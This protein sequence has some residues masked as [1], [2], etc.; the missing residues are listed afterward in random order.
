MRADESY[1]PVEGCTAE[2][3][4]ACV[5]ADDY[6]AC[7]AACNGEEEPGEEEGEIKTGILTVK[8]V[9]LENNDIPAV[10]NNVK[11]L[12][13]KV[14]PSEN[15]TL[16]GITVSKWTYTAST[17]LQS[18]YIR[19]DKGVVLTNSRSM[20]NDGDAY[21]TFKWGYELKADTTT[22]FNV[23][24]NVAAAPAEK[25]QVIL[26]S[27]DAIESSAEK[28]TWSFPINWPTLTTITYAVQT[29]SVQWLTAV[30]ATAYGTNTNVTIWEKAVEVAR[31][32]LESDSVN[33]RNVVLDTIRLKSNKTISEY[34]GNFSVKLWWETVNAKIT[35]D[36]KYMYIAFPEGY[37][38]EYGNSKVLYVYADVIWW[39]WTDFIQLWIDDDMDV[40]A[41]EK[42]TNAT[43]SLALTTPA[44]RA[45][46]LK[47]WDLLLTKNSE[48]TP[49]ASNISD[50]SSDNIMLVANL[51]TN[52]PI[53]V[54]WIEVPVV[55]KNSTPTNVDART[56]IKRMKLYKGSSLLGECEYKD[57]N[58]PANF[59]DD[60]YKCPVYGEFNGATNKLTI[61]VDTEKSTVWTPLNDYTINSIALAWASFVN[62]NYVNT[63]NGA[64]VIPWTATAP[65][66]TV[67]V[68]ALNDIA[69]ADSFAVWDTFVP[70]DETLLAKFKFSSN[71]VNDIVINS[72]DV[73]NSAG[74]ALTAADLNSLTIK[75]GDKEVTK[76][77]SSYPVTFNSLNMELKKG[78]TVTVELYWDIVRTFANNVE[79][80]INN[81]TA[82]A[83]TEKSVVAIAAPAAYTTT[84]LTA[85]SQAT[86]DVAKLSATTPVSNIIVRWSDATEIAKYDFKF[87][88]DDV[89]LNSLALE[90]TSDAY[91]LAGQF[92]LWL[93]S[94]NE[95]WTQ[96]WT[97]QTVLYDSAS[98]KYYVYFDN[99]NTKI[100]KW[101]TA[102]LIVK[103]KTDATIDSFAKTNKEV[104]VQPVDKIGTTTAKSVF[105]SLA[106]SV[107]LT[108][109]VFTTPFVV[110]NTMYVRNTN[111]NV[112]VVSADES[113]FKLKLTTE[114]WV[115]AAIATLPLAFSH[116]GMTNINF[117]KVTVA[118]VETAT[119]TAADTDIKAW[120]V[121]QFTNPVE[122]DGN[123][124]EVEIF[125]NLVI[126]ASKNTN[127]AKVRV[128][129]AGTA[130]FAAA[131]VA[132]TPA[133]GLEWFDGSET[134]PSKTVAKWFAWYKVT[135][136]PTAW[137]TIK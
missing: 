99:L 30:L 62:V 43:L 123:W 47:E 58:T 2:E 113:S 55:V 137:A 86:V 49:I 133:R 127:T 68:T 40:I 106:N 39:E 80:K 126:D 117:E 44:S 102:N 8:A 84:Q 132:G 92:E 60:Y 95:T 65:V 54:E 18:L 116:A 107:D 38:L 19:D 134:T 36:W 11:M 51:K 29:L 9:S 42:E 119:A 114:G 96:L 6:D 64:V 124:T 20:T 128:A 52:T 16:K 105:V 136:L 28:V 22:T 104:T 131:V 115:N 83:I 78:E 31:Y 73:A 3:L 13:I 50:N 94:W 81:V 37:E 79:F 111:L 122:I 7:I 4:L 46:D 1:T 88:K 101:A 25:L 87:S 129:D 70:S 45:Y 33:N 66:F 97:T 24:A 69:K 118:G 110:S 74:N 57:N 77:V 93:K 109:T 120:V 21:L 71:N 89:Q 56:L 5:T 130:S 103:F 23:Y 112:E 35:L 15:V 90:T 41:Y 27:V 53:Y 121:L 125:Y 100:T 34:Y 67:K 63:D 91:D 72:F 48:E 10:N 59:A 17:S 75:Y 14:T 85:T 135:W 26:K 108:A 82:D 76:S 32:T 98:T 12:S 61:K